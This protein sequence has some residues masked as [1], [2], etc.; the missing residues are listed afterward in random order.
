ME[1]VF[2]DLVPRKGRTQ[3]LPCISGTGMRKSVSCSYTICPSSGRTLFHH[4]PI[5]RARYQLPLFRSVVPPSA[6]DPL[7]NVSQVDQRERLQNGK[8]RWY[9]RCWTLQ[10]LIASRDREIYNDIWSLIGNAGGEKHGEELAKM[11]GAHTGTPEN[12]LLDR[13]ELSTIPVATR[14]VWAATRRSGPK[15]D[16]SVLPRRYLCSQKP[17]GSLQYRTEDGFPK[18]CSTRS[19]HQIQTMNRFLSGAPYYGLMP[20]SPSGFR[21]LRAQNPSRLKAK[22]GSRGCCAVFTARGLEVSFTTLSVSPPSAIA[23]ERPLVYKVFL[24][25]FDSGGK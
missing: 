6:A 18:G 8:S 7:I 20:S 11:I 1:I 19:S 25:Y 3:L 14:L 23:E 12:D 9:K 10:E 16:T 24:D 21:W 5:V 2:A 22:P 15:E 4:H 17:R 13:T